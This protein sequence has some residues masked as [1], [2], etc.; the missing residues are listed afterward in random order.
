MNILGMPSGQCRQ[1]LGKM[2]RQGIDIVLS[3]ARRVWEVNP[4]VL[5]PVEQ[6]FDVKMSDR[7]YNEK[8]LEGL[9]YA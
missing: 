9:Y 2:T 3:T 6:A 5:K 4:Q 1:P 8:Y 7:L